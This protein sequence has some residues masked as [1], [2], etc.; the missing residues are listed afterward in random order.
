MKLLFQWLA[1][2]I[3]AG[4]IAVIAVVGIVLLIQRFG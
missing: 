1:L 4:C 3:A 2:L